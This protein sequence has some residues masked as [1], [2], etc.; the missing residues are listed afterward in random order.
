MPVVGMFSIY[1]RSMKTGSLTEILKPVRNS[2]QG[3]YRYNLTEVEAYRGTED[4]ACHASKGKTL[5]T[6]VM[7]GNGG[8]LYIYLIYGM[9]WM[10]NIVTGTVGDP[11]AVLIRSIGDICG[12][13]R[14]TRKLAIDRSFYGEDLV[15]SERIWLE[16]TG[17]KPRFK[18][19]PRIRIDYAGD[20]W[21]SVPWRY[22]C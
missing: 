15:T 11:Q 4:K 17:F 14:L 3:Y 2:D 5:R 6:S 10:L 7:F 13:G 22:F 8:H 20:Y 16:D 19:G 9:Y 21:K 18:T 12:P 1:G